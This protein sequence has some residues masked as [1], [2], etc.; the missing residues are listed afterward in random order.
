MK[1]PALSLLGLV[2]ALTIA[3]GY[4]PAIAEVE[5]GAEA[6]EVDAKEYINTEPITLS[7][8]SGRLIFLELWKTT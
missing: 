3:I 1:V 2:L 4:V 8:L 6:P 5:T 7:Q